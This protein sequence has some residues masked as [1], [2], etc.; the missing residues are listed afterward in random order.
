V[1]DGLIAYYRERWAAASWSAAV[2]PRTD[3]ARTLRDG[4]AGAGIAAVMSTAVFAAIPPGQLKP[5][6]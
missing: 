5:G 6:R 4:L 2:S 3:A 1:V